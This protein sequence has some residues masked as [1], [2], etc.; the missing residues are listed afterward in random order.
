MGAEKCHHKAV[1]V[2]RLPVGSGACWGRGQISEGEGR[3]V[4][5]RQ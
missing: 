1:M 2:E 3:W 5:Q 4:G